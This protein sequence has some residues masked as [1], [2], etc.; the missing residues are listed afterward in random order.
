MNGL[1]SAAW[2]N[3]EDSELGFTPDK[4][5]YVVG[6]A[7]LRQVRVENR[8][9]HAVLFMLQLRNLVPRVLVTLTSGQERET[10]TLVK[11]EKKPNLSGC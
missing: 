1:Y 8:E 7:R 2:Y 5:S 9:C 3:G 11:S 10:E 4:I 6:M